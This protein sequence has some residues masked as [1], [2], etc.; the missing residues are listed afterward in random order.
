MANSI[1]V[2]HVELSN[3]ILYDVQKN[4]VIINHVNMDYDSEVF[5]DSPIGLKNSGVE[6][7]TVSAQD[8]ATIF[9]GTVVE[10]DYSE[11]SVILTLDYIVDI[12][13]GFPVRENI[14]NE[15]A[16]KRAS[17]TQ[18]TSVIDR[19]EI[20]IL[21]EIYRVATVIDTTSGSLST[22]KDFSDLEFVLNEANI[23]IEDAVSIINSHT[24]KSLT[25]G[26]LLFTYGANRESKFDNGLGANTNFEQYTG[27]VD[28]ILG[29]EF[30]LS[31]KLSPNYKFFNGYSD[32]TLDYENTATGTIVRN[33]VTQEINLT[34]T[35]PD[36][37]AFKIPANSLIK[38]THGIF[39]NDTVISSAGTG[40]GA[41]VSVTVTGRA[42][43]EYENHVGTSFIL[44]I[45][46]ASK[47]RNILMSRKAIAFAAKAPG[48]ALDANMAVSN[49]PKTGLALRTQAWYKYETKKLNIG[50]DA[51][52]GVKAILPKQVFVY[53]A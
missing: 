37:I 30:Y 18:A 20:L 9:T 35:Y 21:E 5:V 33:P 51:V 27:Y 53:A 34:V 48:A 38:G 12:T 43:A 22:G 14:F 8:P 25:D 39:V 44:E 4:N 13:N 45:A 3:N 24:R 31:P 41:D 7:I 17:A 11:G 16:I 32:S 1:I 23:A 36:N 10:K 29:I 52:C 28:T 26:N 42:P 15:G 47:Y 49:D 2:D 6:I 50:T 19:F 40:T 46:D